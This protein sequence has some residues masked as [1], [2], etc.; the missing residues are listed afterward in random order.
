MKI[1][2]T[3]VQIIEALLYLH[4]MVKLKHKKPTISDLVMPQNK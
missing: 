4:N 3:E 2:I 1:R